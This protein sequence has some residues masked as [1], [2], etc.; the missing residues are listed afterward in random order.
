MVI[1]TSA[2]AAILFKELDRQHLLD[3]ID[4]DPECG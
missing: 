1:D 3:A 4:K 2:L